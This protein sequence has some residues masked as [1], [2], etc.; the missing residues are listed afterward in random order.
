MTFSKIPSLITYVPGPGLAAGDLMVD[1]TD[2]NVV[3][4][5]MDWQSE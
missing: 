2:Q 5:L 1:K 4:D 3:L